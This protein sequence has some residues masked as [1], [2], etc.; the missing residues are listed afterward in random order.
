MGNA[1][2]SAAKKLI[3]LAQIAMISTKVTQVPAE[4][5]IV[6]KSQALH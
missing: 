3:R 4:V 6:W 5:I 2:R 1:E